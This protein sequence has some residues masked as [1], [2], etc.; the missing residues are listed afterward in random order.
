MATFWER[1]TGRA[2]PTSAGNPLTESVAETRDS[3]TVG[4][5]DISRSGFEYDIPRGGTTGERT[6]SATNAR[7]QLMEELYQAYLTCPWVSTCIDTIAR[8]VTA[9]GLELV[10]DDGDTDTIMPPLVEHFDRLMRFTNDRE[11]M[12]QLLRSTVTDMLVFG[13]GFIEIGTAGGL[14]AALWTLDGTTVG[15]A[16]DEHG[17]LDGYVQS[18]DGTRI[19]EFTPDE[20]IHISLDS[21]RGG[22]YGVSPVQKLM[23]T[24]TAWLFTAAALKEHARRGWPVKIAVDLSKGTEAAEAER[25]EQQYQ[26]RHLGA[27]S[28]GMP[29]VTRV[30]PAGQPGPPPLMEMQS[31]KVVELLETLR[32]LRDEII[33][34]TG[35][36][37]AMV[38]VIESGNL[39][40]GTGESQARTVHYGLTVPL[41][42]ILLEKINYALLTK[43]GVVGWRF[44]FG[45][46]DYRDS[47]TIEDIRDV[48]LR[49]GS[50]TLNNYIAELGQDPVDYG[51]ERVLVD[52]QNLVLW[53][54]VPE[55]SQAKIDALHKPTAP[56]V[57]PGQAAG[58]PVAGEDPQQATSQPEDIPPGDAHES[59]P[60]AHARRLSE[61]W[62]RAYA[63]QRKAALR[64]L[65]DVD[66]VS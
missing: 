28:A 46:V 41:Q 56:P 65:P 3:N 63:I 61:A 52:R 38:G 1:L 42:N 14:P 35:L 57:A 44:R 59:L 39:G 51:N 34:G 54:Q 55:L 10:P 13:D 4:L 5:P 64:D 36:S 53:E 12:I 15:V 47:K 33:S 25:W 45:E 48:R 50:Y 43:H 22:V 2:T 31:T 66:G 17:E 62:S 24:I 23:L 9:G 32:Q 11:D 29:I 40:G 6:R 30:H 18:V 7:R 19:A 37:P 49:N 16:A 20:V 27:R 8:M 58:A 21:P 60:D 26:A